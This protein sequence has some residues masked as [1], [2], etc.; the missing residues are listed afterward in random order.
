MRERERHSNSRYSVGW[1]KGDAKCEL[2]I[3]LVLTEGG[4]D[5]VLWYVQSGLASANRGDEVED[6]LDNIFSIIHD[7]PREGYQVST[8]HLWVT[9]LTYLQW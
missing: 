2:I 1:L 3:M 8:L 5:M 6:G 4:G 7:I 9:T